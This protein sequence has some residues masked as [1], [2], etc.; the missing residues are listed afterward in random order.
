MNSTNKITNDE[1]SLLKRVAQQTGFREFWLGGSATYRKAAKRLGVSFKLDD[2]DLA[3]E[4]KIEK[5]KNALKKLTARGFEIIKN[6]P[7]YLKFKKG[8]QIIVSKNLMRLDIAF[9]QRLSD[10]AHFN[11]ESIF[12]HY[13][14]GRIYDPCGA[15]TTIKEKELIPLIH[16]HQENP[17]I[18]AARFLK[19][20]ARFNVDFWHDV[21]LKQFAKQLSHSLESWSSKDAFHG[22]YAREHGYFGF[23]QA[24]LRSTDRPLL[25]NNVA[26]SG[27]LHAMFPEINHITISRILASKGLFEAKSVGDLIMAIEENFSG[28]PKFLNSVRGRFKLLAERIDSK[29]TKR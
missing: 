10:L 2:Y 29:D 9:V 5:P 7:Y 26:R 17:F 4:V 15:L 20:C 6:R 25:L 27:I 3:I 16:P 11:W 21:K 1:Y 18:L 19:L 28:P 22:K 23:F 12:W 13:P 8:Y 24:I 14:S